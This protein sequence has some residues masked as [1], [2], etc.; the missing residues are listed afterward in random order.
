VTDAMSL[1]SLRALTDAEGLAEFATDESGIFQAG[2]VEAVYLPT[3]TGQVAEVL[4]A[5]SRE[6][7]EV[8]VSGAGTGITGGRVAVDGGW[9]LSTRELRETTLP[10]A[11]EA[12]EVLEA[13]VYGKRLT[14]LLD[15]VAG[16]VL[17]PAGMALETLTAL[18]PAGLIYPPDPTEQTASV[19]GTVATNASGARTFRYGAT[20]QWVCG[21]R[22]ALASGETVTVR[23]GEVTARDGVLEFSSDQGHRH[24]VPVPTYPMPAVKNA[25]GLYAAPGMDL[26]DLFV[27]AEGI[28]GVVTEAWLRLAPRPEPIL[29]HIAFLANAE[30]ALGYVDEMREAGR[31]GRLE[32]LSLEYF[33]RHSLEFMEHPLAERGGLSAVYTELAAELDDL[34]EMMDAL[35]R[36]GCQEDW[37][38][39]TAEE[40][41]EQKAFRH[42][43]PEGINSALRRQGSQKL[44]TDFAVP[45]EGFRRLVGAYDEARA[46]FEARFPREGAH[47]VTFGHIGDCHLHANFITRDAPELAYAK[48]LYVDLAREVVAAGGTLSAEH[49]VGKRAVVVGGRTVPY[50]ELMVGPAGLAQIARAKRALDPGLLLNVGNMVPREGLGAAQDLEAK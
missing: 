47:L 44:G 7:R 31:S 32:V 23:R 18:L 4:A 35:E 13:E 26:V 39:Q 42:S 27:G 6:G 33:D 46:Q 30:A 48:G 11:S 40:L 50:L 41:A 2:A 1:E 22:V 34:D 3:T 38:A 29:G 37:L 5:A 15:P 28:L 9:V 19:G 45:P 14:A 21:L 17:A 20:R 12:L 49:G 10:E 16:E 25:A 36:H 8:T 24:W 43:L